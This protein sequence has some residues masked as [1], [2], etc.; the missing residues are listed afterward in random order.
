M[1]IAETV[2]HCKV[3][4]EFPAITDIPLKAI[5]WSKPTSRQSEGR[6]FRRE[7]LSITHEHK[8]GQVV[9]RIGR[10]ASKWRIRRIKCG[11]RRI[12]RIGVDGRRQAKKLREPA[13]LNVVIT[14][15]IA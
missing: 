1:N 3:W 9:Q 15:A 5:V 7:A 14:E 2:A 11:S 4:P 13:T 6:F 8:I 10:A 12:G